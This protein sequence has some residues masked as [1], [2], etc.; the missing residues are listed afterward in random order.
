MARMRALL[1]AVAATIDRCELS[2]VARQPIDAGRAR[3]QHATYCAALEA[4]GVELIRIPAD[5]RFPDC[6][7]VEDVALDL[8][9]GSRVLLRPGAES[10]LGERD[11][12]GEALRDLPGTLLEMP[13]R[14]RMDGGD[15]VQVGGLL[16][17]GDSARSG[18]DAM[19]WLASAARREVH[20][21]GLSGVLHLKSAMTALDGRTLLVARARLAAPALDRLAELEAR[22]IRVL[23]VPARE[24]DAANVLALPGGLVVVREG[25]PRTAAMLEAARLDVVTVD[26]S[27]LAK[28]EGALTCMSLLLSE[29][30]VPAAP[31][32]LR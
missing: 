6:V 32:G 8:G 7:F 3:E 20:P 16:L 22:G 24:A 23:D 15:V 31:A 17:V 28:A 10:R 5:D 26:T 4:A 13:H 2:H 21:M 18:R 1:R 30:A 14:C 12:V 29:P 25:F 11:A 9:D 27:E 19:A